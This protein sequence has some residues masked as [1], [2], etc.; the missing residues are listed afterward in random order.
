MC[1]C[2]LKGRDMR[3]RRKLPGKNPGEIK[4][5]NICK[6]LRSPVWLTHSEQGGMGPPGKLRTLLIFPQSH[7][8]G[9]LG[10]G[11]DPELDYAEPCRFK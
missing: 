3:R 10:T 2:S 5:L 11:L 7:S 1:S 8:Q 6:D 9:H 4:K